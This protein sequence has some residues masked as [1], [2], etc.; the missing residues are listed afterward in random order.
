MY[1]NL[2]QKRRTGRFIPYFGDGTALTD[3]LFLPLHFK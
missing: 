1:K 3:A 2:F